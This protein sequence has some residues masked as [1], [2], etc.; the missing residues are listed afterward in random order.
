[1]TTTRQN[2]VWA[3]GGSVNLQNMVWASGGSVNL[4]RLVLPHQE[5]LR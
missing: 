4:I 2:I 1:V 5:Q 3:S